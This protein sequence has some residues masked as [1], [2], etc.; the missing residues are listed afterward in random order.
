MNGSIQKDPRTGIYRFHFRLFGR[1]VKKSLGTTDA[2]RAGDLAGAYQLNLQ[3]IQ[4]GR[5]TVPAEVL[6]D[7]ERIWEFVKTNGQRTKAPELAPVTTLEKLFTRYFDGLPAGTKE[8]ASLATERVHC[9]HLMR[10]LG[11]RC[12]VASI[13]RDKLQAYVGARAAEGTGGETIKKELATLRM[14][15]NKKQGAIQIPY[16]VCKQSGGPLD[17]PKSR[18]KPPFQTWAQIEANLRRPG[19]TPAQI[20]EQW[21]SLYLNVAQVEECLAHADAW[22][23]V[24]D[25]PYLYP[26]LMVAAFTGARRSEIQRARR[27][28]FRFDTRVVVIREKKKDR[29]KQVTYRHVDAPAKLFTTMQEYFARYDGAGAL[30]FYNGNGNPLS[31]NDM[32][33]GLKRPFRGSKWAVLKGWHV[34]RHSF[35]S[36]LA[37]K[38]VDQR[39]IDEYMG[40]ETEAMRRRY[41][42]LAPSETRTAA[43]ALW[44]E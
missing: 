4:T 42:H 3:D 16:P 29:S 15:W 30:A 31:N 19:L 17:L 35:A 1:Q 39:K 36:N 37:A 12:A 32:A 6:T 18:E 8:A 20:E 22:D 10:L 5:L 41:R 38:G 23:R 24:A 25:T 11:V 7:N 13:G 40:H 27:E 33:K 44:G 28:D 34:F 26:A 2:K 21:G 14:V 9:R 43:A